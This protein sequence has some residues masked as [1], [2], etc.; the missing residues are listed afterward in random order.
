MD[1]PYMPE[2]NA[3]VRRQLDLLG[4][5]NCR[6]S[7]EVIDAGHAGELLASHGDVRERELWPSL[8]LHFASYASFWATF[9]FPLRDE[10]GQRIRRDVDE[11]L[12]LMAQ[13]NYNCFLSLAKALVNIGNIEHPEIEYNNLQNAANAA[14]ATVEHFVGFVRSTSSHAV[15]ISVE[16]LADLARR[17]ALYRNFIHEGVVALVQIDDVFYIPRPECL[18][19]Y[20][21]WSQ[22]QEADR[23]DFT[24]VAED[25]RSEFQSLCGLIDARWKEMLVLAPEVTGSEAY[26]QMPALPAK[27]LLHQGDIVCSSNVQQGPAELRKSFWEK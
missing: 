26:R 6:R 18:D 24:P 22:L 16:N 17:V 12:E 8:S 9:V 4:R 23:R 13:E 19:K 5:N 2:K 7:E 14:R 3:G 20:R 15:E 25:M 1:L 27:H 11:R 10:S 21:R